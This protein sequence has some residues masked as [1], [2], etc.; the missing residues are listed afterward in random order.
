MFAVLLSSQL[1]AE[2]SVN[3]EQ[4]KRKN[5]T[6]SD[7]EITIAPEVTRFIAQPRNLLI[8]GKW[9]EAASGK[10]FQVYNPATGE[11][12]AQVAEGEKEDID[13]AVRVFHRRGN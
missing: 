1:K 2:L 6:V 5:M 9:V 4:Q 10:V 7:T 8:D 3:E 11:I 13:R 12:L